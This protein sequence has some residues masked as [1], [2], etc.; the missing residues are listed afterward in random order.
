MDRR[1]TIT[2]C[3][4]EAILGRS[5]IGRLQELLKSELSGWSSRLLM[6]RSG[7]TD[8][9]IDLEDPNSLFET[10][11]GFGAKRGPIFH[12]LIEK[13]GGEDRLFGSAEIRGQNRSLIMTIRF[14]EQG[15]SQSS[16]RWLW[17][18]TITFDFL[19]YKPECGSNTA[20]F[21]Q[22]LFEK[23]ANE[24][25]PTYGRAHCQAEYE[26][27]NISTTGSTMAI[28]VDASRYLPGLYWGNFFGPKYVEV[29][30]KDALKNV[31][32]HKVWLDE[33]GV[34]IYLGP[35]PSEWT[36]AEFSSRE[37][38]MLD[39]IGRQFF[40]DKERP[41]SAYVAPN[42]GLPKLDRHPRFS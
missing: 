17:G 35:D 7:A 22:H 14:D 16:G 29:M 36:S 3:F 9:V 19:D 2:L 10:L 42:F 39:Q 33:M 18:N 23:V 20:V 11:H 37:R 32:G 25:Q 8:C 6:H 27:K 40:F 1:L 21:L 31:D 13:F 15:F 28:G 41:E 30:S 24:L 5:K 26:A 12:E 34:V 38:V 4:E